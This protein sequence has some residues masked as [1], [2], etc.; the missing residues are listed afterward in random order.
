VT[1]VEFG[2][3]GLDADEKKQL[4]ELLGKVRHA[5]GDFRS[6]TRP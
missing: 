1:A 5:A 2:M 6:T 4:T 3:A